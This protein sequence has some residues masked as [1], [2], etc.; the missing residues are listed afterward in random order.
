MNTDL[1]NL[2]QQLAINGG[3][4]TID[5]KFNWPVFD[6]SDVAAVTEVARSGAWGNPDCKGYVEKFER[7][8]QTTQGANTPSPVSTDQWRYGLL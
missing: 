8:L 2:K 5:K 1:I 6:E 7:N 4:K 3:P